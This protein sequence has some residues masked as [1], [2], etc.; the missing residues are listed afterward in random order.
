LYS[1]LSSLLYPQSDTIRV[2]VLSQPFARAK[3]ND[4]SDQ[5]GLA[6]LA[7]LLCLSLLVLFIEWIVPLTANPRKVYTVSAVFIAVLLLVC[8]FRDG[9]SAR[10]LGLRVDNLFTVLKRLAPPLGLFVVLPVAVGLGA[11]T[12]NFGRKF[13]SMLASVPLWALLEQ[14]MLLAFANRRLRLIVGPGARSVAATAA[15]FSLFHLPNPV[16]TVVCAAG[17]YIWARE[18]ERNP[19]LFAN[20]LTH[21]IAS[22][23]LANSFPNTL[24]KHLI[25]GY[26]YF[27][28]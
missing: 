3:Q 28:R 27:V 25:V 1:R 19:N 15:L 14:Y 23:V 13:Y 9:V 26:N 10:D 16:L 4:A 22:A 24:L 6:A 5:R 18:Y 2:A 7:E 11:G 21:T 17:G 20:A 12:L 8:Y